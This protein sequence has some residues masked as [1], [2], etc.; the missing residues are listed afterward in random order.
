M[1]VPTNMVLKRYSACQTF[2]KCQPYSNE[3][4]LFMCTYTYKIEAD[5]QLHNCVC[6]ALSIKDG[7]VINILAK[8]LQ[9]TTE[10]Q[11]L[12][13]FYIILSKW[14]T[15]NPYRIFYA[16]NNIVNCLTLK[17]L[18]LKYNASLIFSSDT[19]LHLSFRNDSKDTAVTINQANQSK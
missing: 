12:W 6:W 11:L 18:L 4:C 5:N 10:L 1:F 3:S 17:K 16:E 15:W 19:G 13:W 9:R 8:S 14:L 2:S 7:N